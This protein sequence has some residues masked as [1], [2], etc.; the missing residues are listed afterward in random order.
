MQASLVII[1]KFEN[2]C[3]RRLASRCK[4]VERQGCR[5]GQNPGVDDFQREFEAGFHRPDQLW[6]AGVPATQMLVRHQEW[7]ILIGAL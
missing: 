6:T 4:L 7:G 2:L 3:R 5:N 1:Q